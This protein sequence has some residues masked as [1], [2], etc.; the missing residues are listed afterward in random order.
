MIAFQ[1][2]GQGHPIPTD[3]YPPYLAS[4]RRPR[5]RDPQRRRPVFLQLVGKQWR[6]RRRCQHAPPGL[7]RPQRRRRRGAGARAAFGHDHR[8]SLAGGVVEGD[9]AALVVLLPAQVLHVPHA[10]VLAWTLARRLRGAVMVEAAPVLDADPLVGRL[11]RL[12]RLL[13]A[14]GQGAV[15]VLLL[16]GVNGQGLEGLEDGAVAG[17]AAE[18]AVEVPLHLLRGLVG[19]GS[20]SGVGSIDFR[21]P[22]IRSFDAIHLHKRAYLLLRQGRPAILLL[23]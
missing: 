23:E 4:P 12:L 5:P 19:V 14:R 10:H 6:L 2:Q 21:R 9:A 18:V 7:G 3:P 16:G 1:Y 22:F 17:A 13:L 20:I 8:G 11:W 15:L